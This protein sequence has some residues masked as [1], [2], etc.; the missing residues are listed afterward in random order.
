MPQY[1]N[2]I[3]SLKTLFPELNTELFGTNISIDL[4][5]GETALPEHRMSAI[6]T[7]KAFR[8]LSSEFKIK[9]VSVLMSILD[10]PD[11]P[12]KDEHV[13]AAELRVTAIGNSRLFL[14]K[15]QL[16]TNL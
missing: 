9:S 10:L 11:S 7:A 15:L 13:N 2:D 1:I 5:T 3:L 16:L 12:I 4:L 8:A 14:F 6:K